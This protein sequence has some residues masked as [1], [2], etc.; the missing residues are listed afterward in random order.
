M[1]VVFKIFF[2]GKKLIYESHPINYGM[3]GR[4]IL[5]LCFVLVLMAGCSITGQIVKDNYQE[6]AKSIAEQWLRQE[7]PTYTFDGFN[8]NYAG[9]KKIKDCDKCYQHFFS[10]MSKYTGYGDRN[11]EILDP[12][13]LYHEI[14]ITTKKDKVVSAII[15]REWDDI[16][17]KVA[18]IGELEAIREIEHEKEMEE[19]MPEGLKQQL[20]QKILCKGV[21]VRCGDYDF[22]VCGSDGKNYKND[23]LACMNEDE[24][25]W[26]MIGEC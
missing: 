5:C 12:M 1:N 3:D 19:S 24:V 10:F 8:L 6:T 4:K 21:K 7:S 15:D 22:P 20:R 11:D 25:I 23:C 18:P 16:N 26:Y 13:T 9:S 14:I 2:F 17:S